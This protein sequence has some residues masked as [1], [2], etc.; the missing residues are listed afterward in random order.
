MDLGSSFD[1]GHVIILRPVTAVNF[2]QG[3]MYSRSSV[4]CNL[5]R[6]SAMRCHCRA[7][8]TE[9]LFDQRS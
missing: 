8:F 9:G 2:A 5:V 4:I 1:S 7:T 6:V 3:M